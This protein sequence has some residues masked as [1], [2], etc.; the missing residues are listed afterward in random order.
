MTSRVAC[1]LCLLLPFLFPSLIHAQDPGG[2]PRKVRKTDE[3]WARLLTRNQYLVTRQK[4]TE[5]A[6]SG[7]YYNNHAQGIYKCVCCGT[8]LFS[9]QAKFDSGTGWPSF[10]RP[11]VPAN[12]DTAM[13]F[14][15]GER[16]VEVMC[17]ACG[18][19]LGHVFKDGPPPTGL[20]YC[21]NSLALTFVR[22]TQATSEPNPS[23]PQPD[24]KKEERKSP[25]DAEAS[26][27]DSP[28]SQQGPA[29]STKEK[30]P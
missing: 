2:K 19:H 10:W 5:P 7:K 26:R 18:S 23:K 21:I 28:E 6:F 17:N 3:E 24:S 12:I 27:N 20:R 1:L 9:S 13:D 14:S 16:R 22:P 30:K 4:A 29:T 25:S 11:L 15:T 8:P